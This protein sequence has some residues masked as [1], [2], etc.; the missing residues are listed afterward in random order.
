MKLRLCLVIPTLDQGGA[1]KQLCLLAKGLDRDVFD[2]HVVLLTRSGP[3]ERELIEAGIRVHK[4]NKR[5]KLDPFAW[6]RLRKLFIE[7]RPQLVH[8]WIFAANAYG[9]TAALAAKVPVIIGSE[10]SVDPWKN[11]FQFWI[12]RA[13]AKRTNGLTANSQGTI[14]FYAGHGIPADLFARIPNG[15]EPIRPST[16]TRS[17]AFERMKVPI[18]KRI[19]LS[20]GRLWPQKGYKDLIWS[21]ELLRVM[22]QDM[23][24][25]IIGD[26]PERQRLELYRDN[27]LGVEHV[28]FLGE[29]SDVYELLPHCD[30]LWNGSLYEGQSNVILEAMQA[31]VPVV[32]SDIPGNQELIEH[33]QTGFLYP[34]GV[35]D[36]LTRLTNRLLIDEDLRKSIATKAKTHVQAEHSVE[37]MVE[38]HAALYRAKVTE[39]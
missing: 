22:R 16:L 3:R 34:V 6:W 37:R 39:R 14:D 28:K 30:V 17:Q 33:G 8:S 15:I 10:R 23:C 19:I 36:Q 31:G 20:V 32:A 5:L 35:V 11:A 27:I 12:D 38:R 4:I 25:V 26:G 9:R 29:R 13:I 1:E 18:S 24:Y 2:T 7:L 21:A